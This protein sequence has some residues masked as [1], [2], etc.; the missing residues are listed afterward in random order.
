MRNFFT[1][2]NVVIILFV[3]V[4]LAFS[5]AQNETA[6]IEHLYIGG[7]STLRNFPALKPEARSN[8][9]LTARPKAI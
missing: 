4:L 1:E 9:A 7:Q 3:M 2:R 8:D 6:K 5:V